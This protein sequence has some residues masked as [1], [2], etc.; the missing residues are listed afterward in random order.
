LTLLIYLNPISPLQDALLL[1]LNDHIAGKDRTGVFAALVLSL[2]G[3]S[4]SLIAYDYALTRLGVEPS[5]ELLLQML[6]LWNK[7]W[8]SETPGMAEFVQV[9]GEFI[10]ALLD[11]VDRKYGGVEAYVRDVLGFDAEDVADIKGVLK[12]ESKL[13]VSEA[14]I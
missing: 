10:L 11:I 12:G 8:T 13:V 1:I 6:K 4:R 5:R 3:A 14:S 9:K 7:D 2:A